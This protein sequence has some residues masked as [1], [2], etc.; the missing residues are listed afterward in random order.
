MLYM[1]ICVPA[2]LASQLTK[3][4]YKDTSFNMDFMYRINL[5]GRLA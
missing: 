2:Y 3:N 4:K 5:F 1:Y